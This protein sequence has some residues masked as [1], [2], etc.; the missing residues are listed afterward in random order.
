MNKTFSDKQ[1]AKSFCF[2]KVWVIL[3]E[4][5]QLILILKY[6]ILKYLVLSLNWI[7][8]SFEESWFGKVEFVKLEEVEW[9]FTEKR[10]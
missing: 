9:L 10:Y 2:K 8:N 7:R 6:T 1:I 4:S 5:M 3:S